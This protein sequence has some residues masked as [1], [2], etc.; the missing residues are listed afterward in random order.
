MFEGF[1]WQYMLPLGKAALWTIAL[2]VTSGVAGSVLGLILGLAETSPSRIAR[3]ISTVYVN[4]IR[5]IPLLVIIF[6]IYFGVP[7]LFPGSDIPAFWSGVIALTAFAGAYIAEIFRGSVDAIPK[8][9]SEAAQA[10]GMR[11]VLKYW[12]V[13]LPQAVKIAIP[14][15]IS[16][17]IALIKDSSLITVIGFVE[18]THEGNIVSN[19]SGDPITTYL[20]VGAMYFVICYGVSML[21]RA[22]EKR[23]RVQTDPLTRQQLMSV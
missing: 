1:G 16:F 22:Y 2:C 20:V 14:S 23:Q 7:L 5:G 6:F 15:L 12:Y 21:G 19:L 18:L 8:G 17:L 4:I 11:Y 10:L 13:I 9:Q 3:S